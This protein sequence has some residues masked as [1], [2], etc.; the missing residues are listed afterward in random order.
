VFSG[1]TIDW[2]G[3]IADVLT[4]AYTSLTIDLQAEGVPVVYADPY[5]KFN[6]K[7]ACGSPER[8]NFI[9]ADKTD[10]DPPYS[11]G[12]F[13]GAES[14]HPNR[15]GYVLYGEVFTEALRRLGL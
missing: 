3:E 8:I 2:F 6:G 15:E 1:R 5:T 11:G 10:G 4:V 14:L 9:V 13:I 7:G 12:G